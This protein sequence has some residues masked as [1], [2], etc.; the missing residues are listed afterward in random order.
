MRLMPCLLLLALPTFAA[1][2]G[3]VTEELV[4][5]HHSAAEVAG[6]FNTQ[7]HRDYALAL[8]EGVRSVRGEDYS[9]VLTMV[10]EPDG[11]ALLGEVIARFD[12]APRRAVID[13][14]VHGLSTAQAQAAGVTTPG[15]AGPVMV[16]A[17]SVRARLAELRAAPPVGSGSVTIAAGAPYRLASF[18][19]PMTVVSA[20]VEGDRIAVNVVVHRRDVAPDGQV[21]ENRSEAGVWLGHGT[22]VALPLAEPP[23]GG[24]FL[25]LEARLLDR[26]QPVELGRGAREWIEREIRRLGRLTVRLDYPDDIDNLLSAL[27]RRTPVAALGIAPEW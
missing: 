9:S 3:E 16:D 27:T 11:V 17:T 8:P 12:A 25:L 14:T 5:R 7:P 4:L 22:A 10:G 13:W 24:R 2:P 23:A 26:E 1:A 21:S 20:S 6:W 15:A 19:P 18:A